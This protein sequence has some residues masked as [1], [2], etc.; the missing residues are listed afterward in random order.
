MYIGLM[1]HGKAEPF[2][3][4]QDDAL[5]QLTERGRR[6]VT[7]MAALVRRWWPAG[8]TQIWTSPVLRA[9][10]T[11]EIMGRQV[12][13]EAVQQQDALA[14]GNLDGLYKS[15]ARYDDKASL[16]LIGHSPYLESWTEMLTGMKLDY[17]TGSLAFFSYDAYDGAYGKAK[18]LLY[19][20]PAAAQMLL[21]Q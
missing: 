20:H 16:L 18:L 19:I 6:D 14:A 1:R 21:R 5:R 10:Q 9:R 3:T 17:K 11:A 2:V 13:P 8:T 7:A 15:L 12:R 4:S